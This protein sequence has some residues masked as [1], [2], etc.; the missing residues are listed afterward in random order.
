[1]REISKVYLHS[2][3]LIRIQGNLK[4]SLPS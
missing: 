1:M 3:S 2:L 4:F